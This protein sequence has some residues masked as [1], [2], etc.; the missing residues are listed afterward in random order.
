[1]LIARKFTDNLTFQLTPTLVHR[2]LVETKE[3]QNDV[4]SI[5]AGA[6]YKVITWLTINAEYYYLLP[7]H[8][9][10]NYKNSFSLGV[11]METNGHVF[12]VFVTN[13][14]GLIEQQFIAQTTG[15][16]GDGAI[17]IGFNIHRTFQ[18]KKPKR[19]TKDW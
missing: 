4:W 13:S 7:G 2:N 1:V 8:T 11:D 16:W 6:R 18:V 5:G 3:D 15:S 14:R 12:Q 17:H 10:D 9:A 19:P